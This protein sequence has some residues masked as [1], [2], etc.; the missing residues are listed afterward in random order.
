MA[1]K[2]DPL[3]V[4]TVITIL[5]IPFNTSF[6]GAISNENI[7]LVNQ[8]TSSIP[9]VKRI[10]SSQNH[11]H[12]RLN[13]S[14]TRISDAWDYDHQDLWPPSCS[15]SHQS[16][17]NLINVCIQPQPV[18]SRTIHDPSLKLFLY[19][20]DQVIPSGQLRVS[21]NGHT[22]QIVL[23]RSSTTNNWS[24][25]VSG[26]ACNFDVYQFRQLHFHWHQVRVTKFRS[27]LINYSFYCQNDLDGSEHAIH[28][29]RGAV[30]MHLVHFNTKY[31]N[32]NHASKFA[33][34]LL[35]LGT[36]FK[37]TSD[38][39]PSRI[40][41]PVMD[42]LKHVTRFNSSHL[43]YRQLRLRSFLPRNTNS[44]Y[45]YIGSLT[46]PPCS[47]LVTWLIFTGMNDMSLDQL[48]KFDELDNKENQMLSNT[49]RHLQPLNDRF[50]YVS[51]IDQCRDLK[52]FNP[53]VYDNF[54][55][56]WKIKWVN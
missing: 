12:P 36:I 14:W 51:S 11:N 55:Q 8:S 33:D 39:V 40:L 29:Q 9:N 6:C 20:Y 34:G 38:S 27:S 23:R 2:S 7:Q 4:I 30:E 45:K 35:V 26:S 31:A 28:G 5:I 13:E 43:I 1:S 18:P 56:A 46:T 52:Y 41:Q 48:E 25:K 32:F 24:P 15:G 47:E 16:P 42:E 44:F 50:V 17:I 10:P 53:D 21:N 49:N 22:V 37:A 3:I 19:H 54:H